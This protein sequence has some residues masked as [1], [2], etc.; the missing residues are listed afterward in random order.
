MED[1]KMCFTC[2]WY[3]YK[4]EPD[5]CNFAGSAHYRRN[6]KDLIGCEDHTFEDEWED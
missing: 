1:E 5:H 4:V 3:G 2:V 6:V